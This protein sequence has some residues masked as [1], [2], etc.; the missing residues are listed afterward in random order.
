[1]IRVLVVDDSLTV[2]KEVGRILIQEPGIVIIGEAA[3]GQ[4]AVTAAQDLRPD[5]IVMD[6]VMPVMSGLEA[7]QHIMAAVP[8]P[9]VILSSFINRGERYKTWDAMVAGAVACIE[10]TDAEKNPLRWEKELVRTVQAAARIKVGILKHYRA[11]A[12]RD[13]EKI[14]DLPP[15]DTAGRYNVVAFG[16]STGSIGVI[17]IVLRAF[18]ADFE[19]P[20]LLIIHLSDTQESTFA[21]WL[22]SRC[23]LRVAFASGDEK[24]VDQR[25][26]VLIAPPGRHM[27]V[28]DGIIRLVASEPV[29]FCRPSVDVLFDSLSRDS[30]A[31]PIGVLLTG[32]GRDG[33]RGLK[34]IKE[35]RRGYTICQD[36]ATSIVFGM[37]KA[38]IEMGGAHAV[39]PDHEIARKIMK[40]S[41]SATVNGR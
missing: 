35:Q 17:G 31:K 40:L 14:E 34:A 16:G 4:E 29:N 12:G 2:R 32:I 25:A 28:T 21:Q 8:C 1:M 7:V 11:P 36:E 33:A 22:D 37:P 5:V 24:L 30:R 38:A 20:V 19:L 27:I 6:I 13:K 9:I 41:G 18:P 26:K 15:L 23:R 3:D 10:K 39:L